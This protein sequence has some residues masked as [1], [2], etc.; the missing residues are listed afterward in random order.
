MT[1]AIEYLG[2]PLDGERMDVDLAPPTIPYGYI[3]AA[4]MLDFG[5]E[6]VKH[7]D[8]GEPLPVAAIPATHIGTYQWQEHRDGI[9]RYRW[10]PA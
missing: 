3:D 6:S 1:F 9:E 2:G 8:L 7:A 10:Q 4:D 5:T